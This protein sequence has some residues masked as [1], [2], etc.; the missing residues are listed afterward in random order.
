MNLAR[1]VNCPFQCEES[2][3]Q[4]H[5]LTVHTVDVW[6]RT[7]LTTESKQKFS[8]FRENLL[9]EIPGDQICWIF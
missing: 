8:D 3:L 7:L 9:L 1:G 4:P 2:V 5:S 6:L